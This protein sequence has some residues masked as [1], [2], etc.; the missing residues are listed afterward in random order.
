MTDYDPW[1]GTGI[2]ADTPPPPPRALA[3]V[4]DEGPGHPPVTA[5]G[6]TEDGLARALVDRHGNQLRYCPQRGLWLHWTGHRWL[7]D[8]A[9]QHREYVRGIAREIPPERPWT[10]FRR[11]ALSAAG[12]NGVSRL[13]QTD[14]R[15]VVNVADLD[16]RPY[17]LN[18]PAG[19]VDL[20]TG[21]LRP[22]DPAALH[23][24]STTVA[25]DFTR[26]GAA[27]DQFLATTFGSDGDLLRY[28]QR[29]LGISAIG[30]VLEQ[31]MPFVH[32]PGAN[33]KST[34]MEA[35]MHALGLGGG[36]YAM[37]AP[38][39]MLMSRIYQEHPAEIAQL[40][41]ARLVVCSEL[42][43][44]QKFHEA[45]VKLLTGRDSINARFMHRDPFTFVPSHTL[46][47]LGNHKPAARVGGPAFWRRVRLLPFTHVVPDVKRDPKL[48]EKLAE[49]APAI[50]AWIVR[51]AADYHGT[52]IGEP[53]SVKTATSEYE[54]DQNTIGRFVEEL[55]HLVPGNEQIRVWRDELRSFYEKWCRENGDEPVS[56]KRFVA[57]VQTLSGDDGRGK[58]RG[59]R[60]FSGITL[61]V[62]DGGAGDGGHD[63]GMLPPDDG[64]DRGWYR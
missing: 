13:A 6:A 8:D 30:T 2:A 47:L 53:A 64:Q 11:R 26:P 57:E 9:E 29:L 20:H 50:L 5:Y 37:A 41:G 23:T 27:F 61:L 4:T 63:D 35:I 34:L 24:R 49:E 19:I 58:T 33:G 48:G 52:G 32:G 38:S 62:S 21:E 54:N 22:P 36:G 1:A 3:V 12:V 55:C 44:G 10:T 39:E 60:Y 43:D 25:P 16:A 46:W 31:V 45:R 7:W 18:T 28:V 59:R 42:D 14:P 51:G 17:E 56:Q 40:A 15:I